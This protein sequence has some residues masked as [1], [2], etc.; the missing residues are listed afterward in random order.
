LPEKRIIGGCKQNNRASCARKEENMDT[1]KIELPQ[2]L[3]PL[4][5]E[6][7][8]TQVRDSYYW[9]AAKAVTEQIQERLK[10][11][12]FTNRVAEAVMENLKIGEK[13]Y[14]EKITKQISEHLFAV[15]GVIAEETL[16]KISA[17]VKEYGFIQVG[18]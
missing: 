13:E 12:D 16:K 1:V 14:T 8:A 7:I 3:A 15:T 6:K 4:L 17:K 2:D 10:K 18:R 5:A 11:D 9:E